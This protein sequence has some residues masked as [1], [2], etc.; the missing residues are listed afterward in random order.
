MGRL[1]YLYILIKE[2]WRISSVVSQ[3]KSNLLNTIRNTELFSDEMVDYFKDDLPFDILPTDPSNVAAIKKIINV[4]DHT[5]ATFTAIETLNLDNTQSQLDSCSNIVQ[6]VYNSTNELYTIIR[7]MNQCSSDMHRILSPYLKDLLPA[8]AQMSVGLE[9]VS[10]R[11]A[12]QQNLSDFL[13]DL[14]NNT[15]QVGVHAIAQGVGFLPARDALPSSGIN[16]LASLVTKLPYYVDQLG[17]LIQLSVDPALV[18]TSQ[19]TDEQKTVLFQMME[20]KAQAAKKN[21]A[22]LIEHDYFLTMLPGYINTLKTIYYCSLDLITVA[23]PLTKQAYLDGQLVLNKIRH[24]IIPPLVVEVENLE[25]SMGLRQGLL[26]K[27]LLAHLDNYFS[28]LANQVSKLAAAAGA[29]E[30]TR[31][32]SERTLKEWILGDTKANVDEIFIVDANF[33]QLQD[34]QFNSCIGQARLARLKAIKAQISDFSVDKDDVSPCTAKEHAA[35]QFFDK[36]NSYSLLYQASCKFSVANLSSADK[37]LLAANYKRFQSHVAAQNPAL[38]KLIV[39]CLSKKNT[40]IFLSWYNDYSEFMSGGNSFTAIMRCKDS[41]IC[42]VKQATAQEHFRARMIK[43]SLAAVQLVEPSVSADLPLSVAPYVNPSYL[44]EADCS[45][46]ECLRQ[47]IDVRD[48]IEELIKSDS[49]RSLFFRHLSALGHQMSLSSFPEPSKGFLRDVY[50]SIQSH[51]I[52]LNAEQNNAIVNSLNTQP[53]GNETCTI[54]NLLFLDS[55][56]EDHLKQQIEQCE[57]ID[58][59]LS[60]K[61]KKLQAREVNSLPLEVMDDRTL[62]GQLKQLGLGEQINQF[63]ANRFLPFLEEHLEPAIY[64]QISLENQRLPFNNVH[65][66]ISNVAMYKNLLNAF[67]YLAVFFHKLEAINPEEHTRFISRTIFLYNFM[68]PLLNEYSMAVDK[69]YRAAQ[70]P[71]LQNIIKEGLQ[72]MEPL[73]NIPLLGNYFERIN[74]PSVTIAT[75]NAIELWQS[76]HALVN[77]VLASGSNRFDAH[78]A[79]VIVANEVIVEEQHQQPVENY[80]QKIAQQLYD[81]PLKLRAI[82][83]QCDSLNELTAADRQ[84]IEKLVQVLSG[85]LGYSK[86]LGYGPASLKAIL[87]AVNDV[88]LQLETIGKESRSLV[89]ARLGEI[90]NKLTIDLLSLAD[91][92]EFELGFKREGLSHRLKTELDNIY[93]IFIDELPFER[94]QDALKARLELHSSVKRRDLE[95][96]RLI[97]I[98]NRTDIQPLEDILFGKELPV[99]I[100]NVTQ[101]FNEIID[102]LSADNIPF[103]NEKSNFIDLYRRFQS[104]LVDQPGCAYFE[105]DFLDNIDNEDDFAVAVE[106]IEYQLIPTIEDKLQWFYQEA[107]ENYFGDFSDEVNIYRDRFLL[108]YQSLQPY[109]EYIDNTFDQKY[110]LRDLQTSDDFIAAAGSILQIYPKLMELLEAKKQEKNLQMAQCQQRIEQMDQDYLN[111]QELVTKQVN[112]YKEIVYNEALATKMADDLD[113]NYGVFGEF[114]LKKLKLAIDLEK[115]TILAEITLDSPDIESEIVRRVGEF[116]LHRSFDAAYRKLNNALISLN[117]QIDF[118]EINKNDLNPCAIEWFNILERAKQNLLNPHNYPAQVSLHELNEHAQQCKQLLKQGRFYHKL[119][120]FHVHITSMIDYL[121]NYPSETNNEKISELTSLRNLLSFDTEIPAL[122]RINR[123]KSRM[124][125][126]ECQTI[127]ERSSDNVF[128]YYLRK[129]L[130]MLGLNWTNKE[131]KAMIVLKNSLNNVDVVDSVDTH[132]DGF[133]EQSD[134]MRPTH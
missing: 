130:S 104:Y 66:D 79:A 76:E 111:Q 120:D 112:L 113:L 97:N 107:F 53:E 39:A 114:A 131:E 126:S 119:I 20:A 123:V 46:Q 22:S 75:F 71:G 63:I 16:N 102:R 18:H 98:L 87:L 49:K 14:K 31:K 23:A 82:N 101:Q 54:V 128:I 30:Y 33:T 77:R 32:V 117:E 74:T 45:L 55:V 47:R 34:D 19:A 90:S 57:R 67:H 29:L 56:L 42:D 78:P 73:K 36:I 89:M 92:A 118:L 61:I 69:L 91:T 11:N 15:Q 8:L 5:E 2:D 68:M 121:K 134:S 110:F 116:S 122:Q 40:N 70:T 38:D 51:I 84:K 93:D 132:D 129:L 41:I 96:S 58:V 26:T 72:V 81:I 3:I 21:F 27:P 13:S 124:S 25:E 125:S 48:H 94:R 59:L 17:N 12:Q 95:H 60:Q 1:E 127:L 85:L 133:E 35:Q 99:E 28:T 37:T 115:S 109:L 24:E 105:Q 100:V 80:I 6:L 65:K 62:F 50:R 4:L 64:K 103:I 88:N 9:N 106:Q 108:C 10:P 7:L 86:D 43:R 52:L 44:D 83:P